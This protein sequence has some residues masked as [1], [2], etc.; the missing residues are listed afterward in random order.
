[1]TIARENKSGNKE[2]V[3]RLTDLVGYHMRMAQVAVFQDFKDR[4]G[5][6]GITPAHLGVLLVVRENRHISQTDLSKI[7]KMDRSA[8]V[9]VIDKM[10][11]SGWV[12]RGKT[13]GDRRRNALV[14]TSKGEKL[15][16]D[17]WA[18]VLDHEAHIT[19]SMSAAEKAQLVALLKKV[20]DQFTG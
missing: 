4:L 17:I 15:I 13:E 18:G 6:Y 3:G 10:E 20:G 7:L 1:M 11:G 2:L 5:T 16:H 19:G 8:L 14:P 12:A 9:G